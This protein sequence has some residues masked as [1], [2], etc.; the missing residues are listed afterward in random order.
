MAKSKNPLMAPQQTRRRFVQTASALPLAAGVGGPAIAKTRAPNIVMIVVDDMRFD[1]FGAGGH[2]YIETPNIDRLGVEG[3][4]FTRAYHATPLCSPN[5]ASILT[6]QYASRH[7]IIDNTARNRASHMLDLFAIDLQRTGYETAHI[8][9]WHMGN[10]PSPRPGYDYWVSFE[11]QGRSINPVLYENGKLREAEGYMTDLLTD[12]ALSFVKKNRKKPFF[13]YIG[14]KAVH[15]DITQ[16]DDGSISSENSGFVP[17]PR[18]RGRY[19]GKTV[20]RRPNHGFTPHDAEEKFVLAQAYDIKNSDEVKRAVGGMVEPDVAEDEIRRRA[21]MLLAVDEGLG[22]LTETL[23]AQGLLDDTII[24]FTSDNGYFYGEHG[25]TVERRLPYEE[26]VRMPLLVRYPV[27]AAPGARI[28][29]FVSSVDFAPTALE[30]ANIPI[31]RH[32]QGKSFGPLLRGETKAIRP[33]TL[34]EYYSH[35]IPI[36]W[37]VAMDYRVVLK[38]N[39]KFIKW[40]RFETADELYDLNA[41]PY[42][43]NNLI[44]DPAYSDILAELRTDLRKLVIDS[45]AL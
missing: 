38:R 5:R 8:G 4:T 2:P 17:A 29:A 35:E 36:P 14:H 11:G 42:E 25:L 34:V 13:L 45:M 31:P 22:A 32:V 43:D 15:P 16:N 30:T 24:I 20:A 40:L 39:F 1:E 3:A 7:G 26:A 12:R 44:D 18:H 19:N 10:D 23:S 21:E 6:G 28:D 37:T 41:D 27:W 9:K 33:S